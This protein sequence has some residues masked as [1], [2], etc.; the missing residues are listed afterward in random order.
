MKRR[1]IMRNLMALLLLAP[2]L[3]IGCRN[4]QEPSELDEQAI[5]DVMAGSD[6]FKLTEHFEG[7]ALDDSGSTDTT[8]IAKDTIAPFLWGRRIAGHPDSRVDISVTDDSAFAAY[9]IHT[10]G[11]LDILGWNP[12]TGWV[13]VQKS[14]V[15]TARLYAI[16]KRT[17]RTSD[18]HRG[19][20][21]THVSGA[22]G[23]SD[24]ILTVRI[25][26][27]RIQSLS[28]PDTVLSDPLNIFPL[29]S[30]LTFTPGEEVALT[31]YTNDSSLRL[32]LHVFVPLW[33][34]HVRVPF[35]NMGDQTYAGV[36][37]A[38][39]L[40][41]VRF[42]VFDCLQYETL[43]DDEYPYDFNGWLFPYLVNVT[44]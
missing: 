37:H 44:P 42:A 31:V 41:A 5:A 17:G 10:V 14:L 3:L 24:S 1:P 39:L 18:P 32:F 4:A 13:G 23:V 33:P 40:P 38:Q 7:T 16:F 6:W 19:W 35:M 11:T 26:S 8:S 34:W 25:D 27:V 29:T 30:A 12:D 22:E 20:V 28:Y 21:L 36:W 15:E 43:H 9:T 2:L